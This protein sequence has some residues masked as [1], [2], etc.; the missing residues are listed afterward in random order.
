[1]KLILIMHLM[2]E[3]GRKYITRSLKMYKFIVGMERE[4]TKKVR[5]IERETE[6]KG[7]RDQ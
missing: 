5:D 4:K 6:R 1:M 3:K 2:A 7:E